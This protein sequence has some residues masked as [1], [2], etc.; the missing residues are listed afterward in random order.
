MK[1]LGFI[2]GFIF[3]SCTGNLP[4]GDA[5]SASL[6][7]Q[8]LMALNAEA[9]QDCRTRAIAEAEIFVDSLVDQWINADLMDTIDFPAK[10]VK[11]EAPEPV[12]GVMEK[13]DID[14]LE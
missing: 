6:Y 13:F 14:S 9:D 12:I 3:M 5:L 1:Y 2:L 10:P 4:D 8:K 11:P 7:D